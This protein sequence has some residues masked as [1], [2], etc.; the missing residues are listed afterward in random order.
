M[1]DVVEVW[2]ANDPSQGPLRQ[3]DHGVVVHGAEV[4]QW[5]AGRVWVLNLLSDEALERHGRAGLERIPLP[6]GGTTEEPHVL[7]G[8]AHRRN[9]GPW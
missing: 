6:T 9:P 1:G 3:V 5:H 2:A 4:G 8:P 7:R